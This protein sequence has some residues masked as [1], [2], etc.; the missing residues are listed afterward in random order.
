VDEIVGHFVIKSMSSESKNPVRDRVLV[1]RVLVPSLEA[2][3]RDKMEEAENLASVRLGTSNPAD[4]L[5]KESLFDLDG[6]F[7]EP[8]HDGGTRWNFHCDGAQYP[9]R[10]V[11]LPCPVELHKTHDH[12]VYFKSSDIAQ[13]LV[14]YEDEMALEEAENMPHYKS[15]DYP[16]YYHSGLTPPLKRVVERRFEKR[17]HSPIPPPRTEVAEIEDELRIMIDRISDTAKTKGK[18]KT[19]TLSATTSKVIQEIEDELVDY[20]PWMDANGT[21]PNGIEFDV[22]DPK[23]AKNPSL[24]LDSLEIKEILQ[25]ETELEEK[26]AKVAIKKEE[27]KAAKKKKAALDTKKKGNMPMKSSTPVDDVTQAATLMM[28]SGDMDLDIGIDELDGIDLNDTSFLDLEGDEEIDLGLDL[29]A[30]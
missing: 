23:V 13:L 10:L 16:S 11:N 26:K 19:Q 3:L 29:S 28:Q 20:E 22:D 25:V 30:E 15:E 6:I 14:V 17:D 8:S 5:S 12:V 21:Q 27:K 24:W 2:R 1:L 4:F 18:N 7:C 9:A